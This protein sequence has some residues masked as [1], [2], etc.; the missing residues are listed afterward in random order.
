[1]KIFSAIKEKIQDIWD[2]IRR[3]RE[4][5]HRLSLVQQAHKP[6]KWEARK[7]YNWKKEWGPFI[8]YDADWDGEY[9]IELIIYKLEKM[10]IGLDVY[11]LE[12][13]E[14]LNKR[15]AQIQEAIDLGKKILTY[16]YD[17]EYSEFSRQH[18]AHVI[19]IYR[20]HHDLKEEPLHRIVKKDRQLDFNKDDPL[21]DYFGTS[22]VKKWCEEN[23]YDRKDVCTAYTGQWDDPANQKIWVKM[24]K[25][26]N[27]AEQKDAEKFFKIIAKNYKGWW[28]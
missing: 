22:D 18:C 25:E 20:N 3:Q 19:L 4:Y 9:L 8:K 26:A 5:D 13:R 11:S 28:W 21:D 1:M 7:A 16:E 12:V 24:I 23:N 2:S 14:D 17:K 27:K 15:L 10:Y 6:S